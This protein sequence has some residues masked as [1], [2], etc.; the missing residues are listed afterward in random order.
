M[1]GL[2]RIACIVRRVERSRAE[3]VIRRAIEYKFDGT[4]DE[5]DLH[6]F[7]ASVF[8]HGHHRRHGL[9][10]LHSGICRHKR[11]VRRDGVLNARINV[12]IA[13][14]V[15][16]CRQRIEIV[17]FHIGASLNLQWIAYTIRIGIF[18]TD[19]VAIVVCLS[20]FTGIIGRLATRIVQTN[21]FV[22]SAIDAIAV[23]KKL[24]VQ[25]PV[26]V[27]VRREL[28]EQH[29]LIL[30]RNAIGRAV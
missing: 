7:I 20:E 28:A 2:S 4:V 25:L 23:F 14:T 5:H 11:E 26:H 13:R 30:A 9:V 27:S 21:Q 19:P 29:P 17:R 16:I 22:E 1:D 12:I 10:A 8:C 24:D 3:V 15:V 6:R 18:Q